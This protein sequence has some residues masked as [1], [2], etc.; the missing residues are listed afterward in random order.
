LHRGLPLR[1]MLHG[2]QRHQDGF[3]VLAGDFNTLAP[4]EVLQARSLPLRLRPLI[5]ASGG[6]IRWRTIQTVLDAGY[7]DAYRARHPGQPG[8]TMLSRSPHVRLDYVF[9]PRGFADRVLSCDVVQHAEASAAS[10]H[11]P[12]VVDLRVD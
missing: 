3:H 2:V 4:G 9:V 1:A 8:L 10:D 7:V 5:W 12:V 6:R 11:L